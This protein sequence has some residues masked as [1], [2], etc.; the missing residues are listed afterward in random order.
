MKPYNEEFILEI[1]NEYSKKIKECNSGK[2][3]IEKKEIEIDIIDGYLYERKVSKKISVIDLVCNNELIMRLSHK[4][5]EG[6]FETIKMA[7]G[8]VGIAGLGLGYVANEMA[9]KDEVS[10]VIVYEKSREVIEMYNMNFKESNKIKVIWVD[11]YKAKKETFDYFYCDIY[12]YKLSSKVVG[13]YKIFNKLHEIKE[14]TFFGVEYFLLGCSYN[15]IIWVYI[16]ENWMVMCKTI[17]AVLEGTG[18]IENYKA[19]DE[20]LVHDIL[21]EFK[22]ILNEEEKI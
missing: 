16:P 10:E 4:E 15:E 3:K 2:Y 6:S 20:K 19:L 8:K 5:I 17:A 11:A 18:Y 9:K 12:G 7:R 1:I 13:D 21:K 22:E 14:Y